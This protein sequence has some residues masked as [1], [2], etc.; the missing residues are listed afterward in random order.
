MSDASGCSISVSATVTGSI[1]PTVVSCG[2]VTNTSIEFVWTA[3]TGAVEYQY[4]TDNGLSG[5]TTNT[6][7]DVTGLAEGETVNI[8]VTVVGAAECGSGTE[9]T[10]SCTTQNPG[11]PPLTITWSGLSDTYCLDAPAVSLNFSPT[12]GTVSGNGVTGNQFLPTSAGVGTHTLTYTLTQTVGL[13]VCTYDTTVNVTVVALPTTAID[14]PDALC[15]DADGI[16]KFAGDASNLA[17]I[18]W[19]FGSAGTQTGE[20]PHTVNWAATGTE[21]ITVD[22]VD[23]NGCTA[24]ASQTVNVSD[25]TVSITPSAAETLAGTMVDLQAVTDNPTGEDL[26]YIWSPIDS[27]T[28]VDAACSQITVT[29][30]G[31]TVYTVMVSNKSGCE[32]TATQAI[33]CF[34]PTRYSF[35]TPFRRTEIW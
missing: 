10:G 9:A 32:A 7:L 12:G 3:V 25:L 30:A 15:V 20:G 23:N 2:E 4:T 28:C 24:S 22:V 33:G 27:T 13:D 29:P 6:F 26:T 17:T 1:P 34:T 8:T 19:D 18:S 16:Y 35:P 5:T 21:T 11:C 31:M 14:G